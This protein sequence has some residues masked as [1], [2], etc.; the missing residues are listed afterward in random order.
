MRIVFAIWIL[1]AGGCSTPT[2]VVERPEVECE[3]TEIV[4]NR[5]MQAF[6]VETYECSSEEI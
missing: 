1:L 5:N 3:R 4:H 2:V 6:Y